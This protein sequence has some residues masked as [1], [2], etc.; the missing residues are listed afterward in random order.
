MPPAN[1]T[2]VKQVSDHGMADDF[3]AVKWVSDKETPWW[4][5]ILTDLELTK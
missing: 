2:A 3:V 1:L 4:E 5:G